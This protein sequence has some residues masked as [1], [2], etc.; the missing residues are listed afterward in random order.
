MRG[1]TAER[2]PEPAKTAAGGHVLRRRPIHGTETCAGDSGALD[3]DER[4]AV[5]VSG[6]DCG[7]AVAAALQLS[8]I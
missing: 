3:D 6:C 4:T 8:T 1:V 5:N 2:K 7:E